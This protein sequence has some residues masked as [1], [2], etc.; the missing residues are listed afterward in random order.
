MIEY[1]GLNVILF[2]ISWNISLEKLSK[3]NKFCT[4]L[5]NKNLTNFKYGLIA[6]S[7]TAILS[8]KYY[9]PCFIV[10]AIIKF[11]I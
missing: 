2:F 4:K 5:Y 6:L 10:L 3:N 8:L 7:Y 1:V 11:I 9:L